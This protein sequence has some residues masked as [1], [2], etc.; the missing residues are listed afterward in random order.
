MIVQDR[1]HDCGGRCG[2]S[3]RYTETKK[4]C[5]TKELNITVIGRK[6]GT[7]NGYEGLPLKSFSVT[8]KTTT[9]SVQ[10]SVFDFVSTPHPTFWNKRTIVCKI[11]S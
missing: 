5:A 9:I 2:T 11:I 1:V 3:S 7:S 6:G 10:Q 8:V 4:N